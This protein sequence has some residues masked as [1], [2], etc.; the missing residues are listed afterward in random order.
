MTLTHLQSRV[1]HHAVSNLN[2]FA[3]EEEENLGWL[4]SISSGKRRPS[5]HLSSLIEVCSILPLQ[6]PTKTSELVL[7]FY[8]ACRRRAL[9]QTARKFPL[10][11]TSL[12]VETPI[13]SRTS[14]LHPT[15]RWSAIPERR[16]LKKL[17]TQ[18]RFALAFVEL[19][20]SAASDTK[21][22]VDNPPTH[23]HSSELTLSHAFRTSFTEI[24]GSGEIF[25]RRSTKNLPNGNHRSGLQRELS[26][27]VLQRVLGASGRLIGTELAF[28]SISQGA[29]DNHQ[30]ALAC[31]EVYLALLSNGV[32]VELDA[33]VRVFLGLDEDGISLL[34]DKTLVRAVNGEQSRHQIVENHAKVIKELPSSVRFWIAVALFVAGV[35]FSG[36]AYNEIIGIP[37]EVAQ[38]LFLGGSV[39]YILTG[40][41]DVINA[42]RQA[43]ISF[44]RLEASRL[45]IKSRIYEQAKRN[46][47]H[48]EDENAAQQREE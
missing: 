38:N 16:K 36:G 37:S 17:H 6:N 20:Q 19:L 44:A 1:S 18:Q 27:S 34:E 26:R 25:K 4:P 30:Q 46:V 43:Q 47:P 11:K 29:E 23:K 13:P 45:R 15:R 14:S 32:D 31:H 8:C 5:E 41:Y 39:L 22:D 28:P 12:M 42:W 9:P 2:S 33:F 7:D 21:R 48:E 24:L 10:V 3:Q 40:A 35:L